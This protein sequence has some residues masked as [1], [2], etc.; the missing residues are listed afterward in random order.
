[1][2]DLDALCF[3]GNS[4]YLSHA[5]TVAGPCRRCGMPFPKIYES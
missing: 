3:A 5:W 1:M 4:I 2:T